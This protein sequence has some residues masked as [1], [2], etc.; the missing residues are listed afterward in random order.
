[1]AGLMAWPGDSAW[2]R[3]TGAAEA[4]AAMVAVAS[5]ERG[6]VGFKVF[7]RVCMGPT[8]LEELRHPHRENPRSSVLWIVQ[9]LRHGR[10]LP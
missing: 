7:S 6:R 1:M 8:N 10:V 2:I 4:A 9:I 5:A 3:M